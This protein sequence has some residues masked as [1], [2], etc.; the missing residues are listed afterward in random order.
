MFTGESGVISSFVDV[1]VS[2]SSLGRPAFCETLHWC[3][4]GAW[5]EAVQRPQ[6]C[7]C[8]SSPFVPRSTPPWAAPQSGQVPTGMCSWSMQVP[9]TSSP[10]RQTSQDCEERCVDY[11]SGLVSAGPSNTMS[12]ANLANCSTFSANLQLH[13]ITMSFHKFDQSLTVFYECCQ[14]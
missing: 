2:W 14:S 3:L 10:P 9:G 12:N 1:Q 8:C 11:S 5:W 6:V 4:K 7:R 13:P